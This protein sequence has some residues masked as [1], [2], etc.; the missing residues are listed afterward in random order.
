MTPQSQQAL[1]KIMDECGS[2]TK[3][4]LSCIFS[5]KII[6]PIQSRCAIIR[7]CK[8]SPNHIFKKITEIAN[9]EKVIYT[10]DGLASI[11][12]T[13]NGDM[14]QAINNLQST[15]TGF[16]IVN[17]ENVFKVFYFSFFFRLSFIL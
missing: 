7:Y 6:E 13:A 16:N 10:E 15:F 5:N 17:M 12:F 9:A 1:R 8:L 14:R 4:A 2:N 11:V 3:F